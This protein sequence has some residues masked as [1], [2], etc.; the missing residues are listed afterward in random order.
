MNNPTSVSDCIFYA[1]ILALAF[2]LPAILCET[3][4]IIGVAALWIIKK[5]LSL[6]IK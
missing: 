2:C 1:W 3:L 4:R 5:L 6:A